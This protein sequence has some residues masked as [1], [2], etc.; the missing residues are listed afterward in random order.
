VSPGAAHSDCSTT[1]DTSGATAVNW[2]ANLRILATSTA[3]NCAAGDAFCGI[4]NP[5]NSTM[6]PWPFT[7][8]SGNTSYRQGEFFEGGLNLTALGL[9]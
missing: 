8:K 6:A 1:S 7:D 3:A 5:T 4:V 2:V 9:A